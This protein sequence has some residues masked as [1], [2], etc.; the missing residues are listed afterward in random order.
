M[1]RVLEEVAEEAGGTPAQA[2]LAWLMAQPTITAPIASATG[3]EQVEELLKAMELRLPAG[4]LAKLDV[5]S[6]A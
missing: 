2:A 6:G 5:V 3:V 4:A 1:L